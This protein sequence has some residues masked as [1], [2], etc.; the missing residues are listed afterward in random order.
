MLQ[1]I[2]GHA[3]GYRRNQNQTDEEHKRK[4]TMKIEDGKEIC[5]D[6]K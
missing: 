1:H 6:Q 2:G 4:I 5:T 3:Q